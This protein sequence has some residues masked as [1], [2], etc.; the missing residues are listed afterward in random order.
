MRAISARSSGPMSD[1]SARLLVEGHERDSEVEG[2]HWRLRQLEVK[3]VHLVAVNRRGD[4]VRSC[5]RG[6][7]NAFAP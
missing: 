4:T 5:S 6:L 2:R 7:S 1:P 3:A